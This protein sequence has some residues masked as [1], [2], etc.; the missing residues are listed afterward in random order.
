M[1]GNSFHGSTCVLEI[2]WTSGLDAA[3]AGEAVATK[4]KS[5]GKREIFMRLNNNIG[6]KT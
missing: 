2:Q 1:S 3:N 6:R 5:A 4:A